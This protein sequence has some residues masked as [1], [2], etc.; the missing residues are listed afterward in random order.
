MKKIGLIKKKDPEKRPFSSLRTRSFHVGGYSVAAAVIVI[1][2]AVAVNALVSNL[3]S[4]CT[5]LDTTTN[6]LYTISD[7]TEK[8]LAGLDEDIDIYWIV[9][10]GY[11]DSNIATLL[12]RYCSLSDKIS[13]TKK[14]PDV[15]PTFAK[16]YYDG[17]LY[18]NSLVVCCGDHYRYI[19]YNSIYEYDYSDYYS[20]GSISQNFAGE[21]EITSAISYVVNDDMPTLYILSGHGE[22]ELS[23]TF[24][25]EIEKQ[26]IRTE[27]LSLLTVEAVPEDA[28]ALL[29]NTPQSDISEDEAQKISDY[30]A[31]GGK[32]MLVTDPP[33]DGELTNLEAL[34]ATYGV[35]AVDGIVVEA[36]QNNYAWGTPYYLL[37][38]LKSHSI[39]EPLI[40]GGYYVLLSIAH[41]LRVSDTLPDGVTV[42]T[43]L[44]TSSSAYSKVAGYDSTTYE[45]EDGDIDGAFALGV[46][47]TAEN[48]DGSTAQI[49]WVSSGALLDEQSSSMVSGGNLDLFLNALSWMC[50]NEDGISIH[51]KSM[52]YEYLTISSSGA[53]VMTAVIIWLIPALF[54]GTGICVW[55]RRR[56]K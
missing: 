38:D 13:V 44:S 54:L 21:G 43:L 48:D 50:G 53:S 36:N 29:I 25:T 45:K 24:E 35:E 34:M 20:G 27:D 1:A 8:I 6:G 49:V 3:P 30:L 10:S 14:D 40:D 28:G 4:T 33:Q 39:T 47:I 51:S 16:Q 56:R 32:L 37:P 52:N 18:N 2:I 5:K 17:Q 11:E 55:L 22:M 19:D 7:Q 23:S 15:Y 42:D 41:G 12:D 26:N 9:Q 31:S 46:A